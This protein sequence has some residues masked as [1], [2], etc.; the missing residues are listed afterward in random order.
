MLCSLLLCSKM[1]QLYIHTHILD[2]HTHS[3]VVVQL[4]SQVQLCVTPCTAAC[5]AS[6]SF[7]L[8]QSC[9]N[10]C[11]SSWRCHPTISSSVGPFSS[12]LPSFPALGSFQMSWLFASSGLSIGASASHSYTC[13][14]SLYTHKH[15]QMVCLHRSHPEKP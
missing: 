5:Q 9:S 2:T 14:H 6:L 13:I 12:C 3:Y 1:I 11:P 15:S 7:S 8:S 4:L 10:P